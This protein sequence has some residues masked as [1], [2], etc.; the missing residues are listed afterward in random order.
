M[1]NV[2]VSHIYRILF[3]RQFVLPVPYGTL[4]QFVRDLFSFSWYV[5]TFLMAV[6]V[7]LELKFVN[8]QFA[9]CHWT[10]CF[11]QANGNGDFWND[12]AGNNFMSLRSRKNFLLWILETLQTASVRRVETL[13]HA[14][15]HCRVIVSLCKFIDNNMVRMQHRKVF[16]LEVRSVCSNMVI[17]LTMC[18]CV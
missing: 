12:N 17:P 9:S 4:L 13:G 14:F 18:S 1:A 11:M 16:F 6:W 2:C 7:W 10:E 15:F 5:Y 3:Y 8:M